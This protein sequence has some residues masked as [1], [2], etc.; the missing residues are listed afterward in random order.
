M[1]SGR[2]AAE[3]P[4][5]DPSL[6]PPI[7]R[8]YYDRDP[9]VVARSLLGALLCRRLEDGTLLVGRITETEAYLARGDSAN[10]AHRGQTPRNRSM[11]G[12]PGHAYVYAIHSRH[13][14]NVV[15]EPIGT[16]SAV[17]IRAVEPLVGVEQMCRL[18]CTADPTK[19]TT[20]PGRLCEAFAIDRRL[21]GEDLTR[22]LRLWLAAGEQIPA[23]AVACTPRIGVTSA[24]E[25]PLRFLLRD[26]RF[27]S[28]RAPRR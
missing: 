17:L 7:P 24:K 14:L 20:G 21:D 23:Q 27:V 13:C 9:I 10:H 3:D 25:L 11:F 19:L 26:S 22:P 6:Y 18:R 28:R 16:P 1:A 2:P 8:P 12:P 5:N 15:T 4:R